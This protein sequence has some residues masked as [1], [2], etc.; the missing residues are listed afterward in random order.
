LT[1]TGCATSTPQSVPRTEPQQALVAPCPPL[2][3][4]LAG[5]S[6]TLYLWALDVIQ[7]YGECRAKQNAKTR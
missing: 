3:S 6:L 1:L 7:L 2:P 4:L 5:D